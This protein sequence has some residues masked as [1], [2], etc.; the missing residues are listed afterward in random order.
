GKL[1]GE[2]VVK[3]GEEPALIAANGSPQPVPAVHVAAPVDTTGAGDSFNGAYLAAR[4]AGHAPTEAVL[5]A[6]RV[7][8]AVVQVRGALAPFETLRAA[9][10]D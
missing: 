6:H 8:A 9:Y 1:V 10:E 3:N 5:R 2:V 7:A 4:L